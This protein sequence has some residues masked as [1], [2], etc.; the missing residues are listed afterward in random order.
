MQ[1]RDTMAFFRQVFRK[2]CARDRDVS[3]PAAC[4]PARVLLTDVRRAAI[5]EPA[6]PVGQCH[7]YGNAMLGRQSF[8]RDG[9]VRQYDD[10][11][12]SCHGIRTMRW[13]CILSGPVRKRQ[14]LDA[15]GLAIGCEKNAAYFMPYASACIFPSISASVCKRHVPTECPSPSQMTACACPPCSCQSRAMRDAVSFGRRI[16]SLP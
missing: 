4:P 15:S 13:F 7:E 6:P 3:K 8:P 11:R 14:P 2:T 10:F 9:I 16:S 1:F 5:D 12:F